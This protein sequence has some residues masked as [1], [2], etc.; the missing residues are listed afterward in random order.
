MA[1]SKNHK[2]CGVAVDH[3][4]RE[5]DDYYS[6]DPKAVF[7]L[8]DREKFEGFIHEPACGEGAISEALISRGYKVYSTDLVDRGYGTPRIDYLMEYAPIAENVVTNPP[9]T[10]SVEFVLKALSLTT[11]KVAIPLRRFTFF[12]TALNAFARE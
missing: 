2:T 4:N 9:F 10:L 7:E 12:H 11:G 3:E 5:K 6:T 8:L 1:M